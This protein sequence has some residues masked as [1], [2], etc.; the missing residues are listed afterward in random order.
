MN[1]MSLSKMGYSN[2]AITA[3]YAG[4]TFYVLVGQG[5]SLVITTIIRGTVEFPLDNLPILALI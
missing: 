3:A 1:D 4:P 2:M 5:G